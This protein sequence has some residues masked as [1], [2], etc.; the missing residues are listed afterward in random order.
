[1][2]TI[3]LTDRYPS[4]VG[5]RPLLLD[6]HDPVVWGG[7]EEGP[8]DRVQLDRFG[9]D[10]VLLLDGVFAA[11]EVDE[12]LGVAEAIARR[13]EVRQSERTIVE[14]KSEQVRSVFEVHRLD[15]TMR[16]LARDERLVGAARQILGSDV[17]LHQSR[18][19]F[20]PAIHGQGFFWH[21]DF[22][23]WHTEDGMPAMRAVSFS[24]ALT[25]NLP[26]NGPLLVIPGSHHTFVGC[27]GETPDDHYKQS[28]RTQEIGTPDDESLSM[29]SERAG[30]ELAAQIGSAGSVAVFDCNAMHGS[31]SNITTYPRSNV[32]FVYNSVENTLVDPF[33]AARPRPE[34]IAARDF[35]PV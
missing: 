8:L 6:R 28:L 27:V 34:F 19:N 31:N 9:R 13:P 20:K 26:H 16:R 2:T 15:D 21:S 7:A 25:R 35:T 24:V 4:R 29:L 3:S 23:T 11:P 22:E 17:Y 1:M 10:G 12:L 32:F 14:P 33:S 18:V 30:G 5:S